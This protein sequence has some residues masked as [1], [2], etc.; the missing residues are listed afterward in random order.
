MWHKTKKM[1]GFRNS[2]VSYFTDSML[3]ALHWRKLR[4]CFFISLFFLSR[5]SRSDSSSLG[6]GSVAALWEKEKE[7]EGRTSVC[8][9]AGASWWSDSPGFNQGASYR[10]RLSHICCSGWLTPRTEGSCCGFGSISRCLTTYFEKIDIMAGLGLVLHC[11]LT[12]FSSLMLI[13][14]RFF[15]FGYFLFSAST[16]APWFNLHI[17]FDFPSSIFLFLWIFCL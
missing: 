16:A 10:Y 9:W 12:G 8:R 4:K 6:L 14:L 15:W 2:F 1:T 13:L 7:R 17:S 11:S 3:H 5:L